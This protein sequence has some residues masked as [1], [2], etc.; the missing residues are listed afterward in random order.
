LLGISLLIV[1][2]EPSLAF[3]L[4]LTMCPF[5]LI[6]WLVN[7]LFIICFNN[8]I[9]PSWF[10][11]VVAFGEAS[12][13]KFGMSFLFFPLKYLLCSGLNLPIDFVCVCVCVWERERERERDQVT[14]LLLCLKE[15]WHV[16]PRNT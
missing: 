2:S 9:S 15:W 1:Y 4:Y 5:L 10:L 14:F 8:T 12:Y 11:Q 3:C 7:N 16:S 6:L 13:P